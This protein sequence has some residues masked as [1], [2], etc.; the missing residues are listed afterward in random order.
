MKKSQLSKEP[1]ARTIAKLKVKALKKAK[2]KISAGHQKLALSEFA[3]ALLL[4]QEAYQSC[5]T[6]HDYPRLVELIRYSWDLIKE[7]KHS[8]LA[9]F[10]KN[11]LNQYVNNIMSL[12]EKLNNSTYREAGDTKVLKLPAVISNVADNLAEHQFQA[13]KELMD[14]QRFKEATTLFMESASTFDKYVYYTQ[15]TQH[16]DVGKF[17]QTAF[18]RQAH[19][20]CYTIHCF[21]EL[22]MEK[23]IDIYRA[24]ISAIYAKIRIYTVDDPYY[25]GVHKSVLELI[26]IY[27][28]QI[29]TTES[30]DTS[31]A[32]YQ[33]KC[34]GFLNL[35]ASVENGEIGYHSFEFEAIYSEAKRVDS[36]LNFLLLSKPL[37]PETAKK[38]GQQ[39]VIIKEIL[40]TCRNTLSIAIDYS[41]E[42]GKISALSKAY[43]ANISPLTPLIFYYNIAHIQLNECQLE[44]VDHILL[45]ASQHAMSIKE[46]PYHQFKLLLIKMQHSLFE[47]DTERLIALL[48][49]AKIAYQILLQHYKLFPHLISQINAFQNILLY[50]INLCY[51]LAEIHTDYAR[52]YFINVVNII[53]KDAL[54]LNKT[55]SSYFPEH[56]LTDAFNYFSAKMLRFDKILF[57]PGYNAIY[58]QASLKVRFEIYTNNLRAISSGI[59]SN[60]ETTELLGYAGTLNS[61][62]SQLTWIIYELEFGAWKDYINFLEFSADPHLLEIRELSSRIAKQYVEG[63]RGLILSCE[64]LEFSIDTSFYKTSLENKHFKL[65]RKYNRC[66]IGINSEHP[67]IHKRSNSARDFL[68]FFN[69][70]IMG[71]T[72]APIDSLSNT[73]ELLGQKSGCNTL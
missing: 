25:T 43:E 23:I 47:H 66:T 71:N 16:K 19:S 31:A 48:G 57:I 17:I 55:I 14:N 58:Q 29:A 4:W 41:E 73:P 42:F 8:H 18:I 39:L 46:S 10:L 35:L 37:A 21:R 40:F 20:Y 45:T 62:K 49:Q 61:I 68:G 22:K 32:L 13:A 64:R 52:V 44:T 6:I 3:Q 30:E 9:D 60:Q 50:G 69:G 38:L 70:E 56:I 65:P 67:L 53:Y 54:S 7:F 33:K 24:K 26:D 63:F 51:N 34:D 15:Q 2:K 11:F 36:E 28:P 12:L 72:S 59:K 5:V 27:S 1:D